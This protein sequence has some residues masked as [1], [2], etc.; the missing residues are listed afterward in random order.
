MI[1]E[2][3]A[4][5]SNDFEIFFDER[6]NMWRI[7]ES[8]DII[9]NYTLDIEIDLKNLNGEFEISQIAPFLEYIQSNKEIMYKNISDAKEVL[10]ALFKTIYKNTFDDEILEN[11]DFN[12]VGIDFKGFSQNYQDKFNYDF[13]FFPFYKKDQ[14]KDIGAFLWKAFFRDRLLLGVYSDTQ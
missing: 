5:N 14:Y 13:Q 6:L 10:L 7:I 1:K 2:I 9:T 3:I 8:K 12:F 4:V 11:I